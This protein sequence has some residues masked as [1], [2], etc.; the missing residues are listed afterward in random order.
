M[1]TLISWTVKL[2]DDGVKRET[3]VH[4]SQRNLKW[5]FKRTDEEAWDYD[6]PPEPEDWDMLEDV[7]RRRAGR[8][9][10][11]NMLEAVKALRVKA[12]A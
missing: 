3:R 10:S 11:V 12:G 9:N 7:L 4:V 5:Q 2:P 6:S 8:G 1:H